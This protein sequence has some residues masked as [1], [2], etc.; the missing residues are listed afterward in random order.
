LLRIHAFSVGGIIST[1]AFLAKD[2]PNYR[3]GYIICISFI[4]LSGASCIL[5]LIALMLENN[6]RQRDA[7]VI[8]PEAVM[9][10]EESI[11]EEALGDLAPTY[12][13]VY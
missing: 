8:N 4:C 13:Y 12:R 6:K 3:P 1:F 9:A 10:S 5:Y 11:E 7:T 2:A